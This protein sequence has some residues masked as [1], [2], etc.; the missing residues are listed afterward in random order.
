[1]G[2]HLIIIPTIVLVECVDVIEKKRVAYDFDFVLE[3][4]EDNVNYL[5]CNGGRSYENAL[6][7]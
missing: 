2:K 7:K 1:M 5:I 3:A 6:F 4:V